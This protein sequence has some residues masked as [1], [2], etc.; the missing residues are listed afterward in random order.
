MVGV[1]CQSLALLSLVL[2]LFV[3]LNNYVSA[4]FDSLDIFLDSIQRVAIVSQFRLRWHGLFSSDFPIFTAFEIVLLDADIARPECVLPLGW[5]YFESFWCQLVLLT[6]FLAVDWLPCLWF[7]HRERNERQCTWSE[8]FWD[9]HFKSAPKF[10]GAIRRTLEICSMMYPTIST[11][12]LGSFVCRELS[13]EWWIERDPNFKCYT[14]KH[15]VLLVISGLLLPMVFGFPVMLWYIL[16]SRQQASQLHTEVN[17]ATLGTLYDRYEPPYLWWDSWRK[18]QM[19]ALV[20]IQVVGW[21]DARLQA[22]MAL[23]LF[24]LSFTT[25]VYAQPYSNHLLDKLDSLSIF[26]SCWWVII[27][28]NFSL[29]NGESVYRDCFFVIAAVSIFLFLGVACTVARINIRE[30]VNS[31][32][33]AIRLKQFAGLSSAN[34]EEDKSAGIRALRPRASLV[35]A[36]NMSSAVDEELQ[37]IQQTFDGSLLLHWAGTDI[38]IQ[39]YEDLKQLDSLLHDVVSDDSATSQFSLLAEARFYRSVE[40]AFP[41]ILQWIRNSDDQVMRAK[42]V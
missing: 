39:S 18:M 26:F 37:E 24:L 33:A 14:S 40:K 42:G 34:V 32:R 12:V 28:I 9:N 19:L 23:L 2:L 31:Q 7:C 21:D 1:T 6:L 15:T 22:D 29:A 4:N 3:F 8:V 41:R 27:G 38:D 10:Q 20:C 16:Y 36:L 17:L 30:R 35:A 13:G 5:S 25:H 11:Y